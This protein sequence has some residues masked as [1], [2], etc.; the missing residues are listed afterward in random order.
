[1]NDN[2]LSKS[3][4]K[5]AQAISILGGLV[6]LFQIFIGILALSKKSDLIGVSIF[7]IVF[8]GIL[9]LNAYLMLQNFSVRSVK[10]FSFLFSFYLCSWP[11]Q[12][13]RPLLKLYI[14][15]GQ[16]FKVTFLSI[17]H[18][19]FIFI[20]YLLSKNI[21]IKATG[22]QGDPNESLEQTRTT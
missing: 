22:M 20:V 11:V 9:V 16:V 6:G 7:F 13:I 21:I 12:L 8:G 14:N 5:L 4:C 1:M 2:L 19:I 18:I 17:I 3:V 10:L 15:E